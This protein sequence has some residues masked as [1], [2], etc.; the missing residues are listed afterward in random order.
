MTLSK[1]ILNLLQTHSKTYIWNWLF[2][3]LDQKIKMAA[4]Q[5]KNNYYFSSKNKCMY[6][7]MKMFVILIEK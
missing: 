2:E 7:F 4:T 1:V 3:Q 5:Y 6:N